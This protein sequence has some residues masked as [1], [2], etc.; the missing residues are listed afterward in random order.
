[1]SDNKVTLDQLDNSAIEAMAGSIGDVNMLNTENKTIVGAL[2]EI[3]GKK[4]IADAIGEPLTE[5][6]KFTEMGSEING[7]LSTFKTNMMNAGVVVEDGDKFKQLIEKVTTLTLVDNLRDSLASILENKG[8][9]V[10]EEDDMT[11]LITK[12]DEEFN[13]RSVVKTCVYDTEGDDNKLG[14][15]HNSTITI[16]HDIGSIPSSI[17]CCTSSLNYT[18]SGIASTSSGPLCLTVDTP[19][20]VQADYSS[21]SVRAHLSIIDVNE[22]TFTVLTSLPNSQSGNI[23]GYISKWI[24]FK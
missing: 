22:T 12:V 11:S 8:V 2:A 4:V 13:A 23:S 5:T 19:T 3:V 24:V 15:T 6:D 1:M 20:Y 17:I 9:N 7:L 18:A 14:A 10:T 21:A 16:T